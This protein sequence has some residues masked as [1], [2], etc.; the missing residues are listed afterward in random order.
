MQAEQ[1]MTAGYMHVDVVTG[2]NMAS[3][4]INWIS[5]A[6]GTSISSVTQT[7]PGREMGALVKW[8]LHNAQSNIF[9]ITKGRNLLLNCKRKTDKNCF[10]Q[11]I[12]QC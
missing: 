3:L 9:Q 12:K 10:S 6:T 7:K 2:P 1:Q 8:Y 4:G 5:L 11:Y